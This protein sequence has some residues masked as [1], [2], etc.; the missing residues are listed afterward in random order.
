[1]AFFFYFWLV[2]DNYDNSASSFYAPFPQFQKTVSETPAAF[3]LSLHEIFY[4]H[5]AF[6]G[7]SRPGSR[8]QGSLPQSKVKDHCSQSSI[9]P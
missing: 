3:D 1:V 4:I 7:I 5:N 9:P 8:Q 2:F 6:I